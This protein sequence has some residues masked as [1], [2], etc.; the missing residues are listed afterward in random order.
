MNEKEIKTHFNL[1]YF[2]S[3][4]LFCCSFQKLLALLNIWLAWSV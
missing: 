4:E 1:D 2:I 3:D